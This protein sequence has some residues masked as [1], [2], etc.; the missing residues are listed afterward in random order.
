MGQ[1]LPAGKVEG[2]FDHPLVEHPSLVVAKFTHYWRA[3]RATSPITQ[4]LIRASAFLLSVSATICLF[5]FLPEKNPGGADSALAENKLAPDE[6]LTR[7]QL[8]TAIEKAVAEHLKRENKLDVTAEQRALIEKIVAERLK[9]GVK[10]EITPGQQAQI[11]MAVAAKLTREIAAAEQKAEKEKAIAAKL[12][13]DIEEAEAKAAARIEKLKGEVKAAEEKATAQKEI[14]EK[15]RMEVKAAEEN[16]AKERELVERLQ[17][18]KAVIE[19]LLAAE[20]KKAAPQEP[21]RN[22]A[23]KIPDDVG[24]MPADERLD[25]DPRGCRH[26]LGSAGRR[27]RSTPGSGT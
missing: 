16:A 25:I 6:N 19:D 15:L 18:E 12:K 23:F 20:A 5:H 11:E 9:S 22:F 26:M 24:F 3:F 1:W 13:N 21:K 17:K 14:A 10:G 8:K 4:A 7:D 27:A 2:I